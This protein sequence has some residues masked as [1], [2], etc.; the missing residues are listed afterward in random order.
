[1]EGLTVKL[2]SVH[3]LKEI[4]EKEGKRGRWYDYDKLICPADRTRS[5]DQI[6]NQSK[7]SHSN[8]DLN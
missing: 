3:G 7:S 5:A 1:M 8:P 2:Q 6:S 4:I